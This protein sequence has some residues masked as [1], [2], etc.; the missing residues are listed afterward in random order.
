MNKC[1]LEETKKQVEEV[2]NTALADE[3]NWVPQGDYGYR[4]F[5]KGNKLGIQ[6]EL[7]GQDM[8]AVYIKG[9]W[10]KTI[11]VGE[12]FF[13]A[14]KSRQIF[15]NLRCERLLALLTPLSDDDAAGKSH[16]WWKFWK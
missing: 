7:S 13:L 2:I 12:S 11:D 9:E 5:Y 15:D 14:V 3:G 1:D 10:V 8:W 6:A 4:F 16:S